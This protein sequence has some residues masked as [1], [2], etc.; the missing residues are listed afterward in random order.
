MMLSLNDAYVVEQHH[1]ADLC[2]GDAACLL[3]RIN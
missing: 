3:R 1:P 2:M